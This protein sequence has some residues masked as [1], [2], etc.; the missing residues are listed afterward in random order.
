M[1]SMSHTWLEIHSSSDYHHHWQSKE[2]AMYVILLTEALFWKSQ[3][4][5][6]GLITEEIGN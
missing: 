2:Y 6:E 1:N 5:K 4:H 3:T